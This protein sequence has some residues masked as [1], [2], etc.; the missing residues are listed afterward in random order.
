[1]IVTIRA[2]VTKAPEK[3]KSKLLADDGDM[4]LLKLE[5]V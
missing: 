1:M 2:H 3:F 5:M 4:E